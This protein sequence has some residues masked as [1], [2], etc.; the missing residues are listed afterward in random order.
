MTDQMEAQSKALTTAA[1]RGLS[2]FANGDV[3]DIAA[4]FNGR[5]DEIGV[6]S[7]MFLRFSGN[8]GEWSVKGEIVP[9]G[10]HF[11][12]LILHAEEGWQC[13]YDNK[14]I[15]T[16]LN[17]VI[18]RVPV[19]TEDKL[20]PLP[21]PKKLETDG[22]RRVVKVQVRDLAGGPQMDLTLPA[23]SPYRPIWRLI[24]EYGQKVRMNIDENRRPKIPVIEVGTEK[25]MSKKTGTHKFAP[26][27]TIAGWESEE[28][29]AALASGSGPEED[30]P[31]QEQIAAPAVTAPTVQA[32]VT[33]PQQA[34]AATPA[35][36]TYRSGRVG[37]RV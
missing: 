37:K 8:T 23:E 5:T 11:A 36:P 10:T 2:A 19:P 31:A 12:F 17:P 33:I 27:L 9:P 26:I 4:R 15:K 30:V 34:S 21:G 13:W 24:K 18:D 16:L 28:D 32:E 14:P 6:S 25:F 7:G 35:A 3:D 20:P 29:L 1:A 22:W